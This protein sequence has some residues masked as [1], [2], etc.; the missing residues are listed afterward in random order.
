MY[1]NLSEFWFWRLFYFIKTYFLLHLY[2]A[3]MHI[4]TPCAW[5]MPSESRRRC[6]ITWNGKYRRLSSSLWVLTPGADSL[7]ELQNSSLLTSSQYNPHLQI[8][9]S[10]A[11]F[12]KHKWEFLFAHAAEKVSGISVRKWCKDNR[13]LFFKKKI[14]FILIT[15]TTIEFFNI[16][17]YQASVHVKEWGQG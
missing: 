15:K 6:E 8:S 9:P 3:W 1:W 11:F 16:V 12:E 4:Y 14:W 2:F 10:L 13:I 7:W 17:R 5:L